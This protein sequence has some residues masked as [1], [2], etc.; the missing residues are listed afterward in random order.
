MLR[1]LE[2]RF[3]MVVLLVS[4]L[5]AAQKLSDQE[6]ERRVNFLLQ[7]MTIEEEAG[8]LTQFAGNS[9]QNIEMIKQG[10]VG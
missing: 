2:L 5:A 10:K 6:I 8:Q 1:L 4:S 7:Q 9:P 3:A